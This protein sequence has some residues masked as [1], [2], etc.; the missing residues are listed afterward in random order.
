MSCDYT[1]LALG[2]VDAL[3]LYDTANTALGG[4]RDNK[5]PSTDFYG[6]AAHRNKIGQ[7]LE[8]LL[9]VYYDPDG[10]PLYGDAELEWPSHYAS[11]YLS[12][13]GQGGNR[14]ATAARIFENV[15]A[16]L[17]ARGIEWAIFD[18]QEGTLING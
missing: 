17:G 2:P 4:T 8:A 11:V 6:H 13:G 3:D 15:A 14:D 9:T 10:G 18:H 5:E 7:G 1:I 12:I 16:W